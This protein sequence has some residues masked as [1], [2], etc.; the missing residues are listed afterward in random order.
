LGATSVRA[1]RTKSFLLY[2]AVSTTTWTRAAAD[3]IP[4]NLPSSTTSIKYE[5]KNLEGTIPT[6][7]GLLTDVTGF[8][9]NKNSLTGPMPTEVGKMHKMKKWFDAHSNSLSGTLPTELGNFV[10]LT[11]YFGLQSNKISGTVPSELGR[12]VA[13][14]SHFR[15]GWNS[16]TGT[17]PT[18]L[19]ELV[20]MVNGETAV[21]FYAHS[22]SSPTAPPSPALHSHESVRISTL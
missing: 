14:T 12:L 2:A 17:I 10:K 11:S 13:M 16:F 20:N 22:P 1:R 18:E 3:R 7:L 19:G 8:D 15:V 6:E 9:V 4:T 21:V 5:D